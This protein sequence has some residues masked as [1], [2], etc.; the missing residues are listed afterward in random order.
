MVPG[1]RKTSS[2]SDVE[3]DEVIDDARTH[4]M[5]PL[6][7]IILDGADGG[8]AGARALRRRGVPVTMISKGWVTRARGIDGRR[9]TKRDEWLAELNDVASLGPGVLIP[10]SDPAVEFVARDR[11]LIPATLRSFEGPDSAHIKLMDKASLYSIAA[12]AGVRTPVVK[13]L[14]SR[15]ELEAVA[16]SAAYPSLLKPVLSHKYRELFGHHRNILVHDPDELKTA[17][18][19]ALDAGLDW[20]VTEVIPG[21]ETSLFGAVTIRLVD[22]SLALAYTRRKLRQHPPYFGAG[23]VLETV[24]APGAME[25]AERLLGAAGFV[26]FSSLEAKQHAVT[27]EHVLMEVNVRIPQNLGLGEAAGVDPTWRLYATLADIP[28]TPQRPQRNNVKV[29]VP[30]LELMAA[31]AYVRQGDMTVGDVLR[32]Y[33]GVRSISGLSM[34]DPVPLAAFVGGRVYNGVK[35]RAA[36]RREAKEEGADATPFRPGT[37]LKRMLPASARPMAKRAYYR[38]VGPGRRRTMLAEE[39]RHEAV[40]SRRLGSPLYGSLLERV[41]DDVEA[42]GPSW[43]LLDEKWPACRPVSVRLMGGV[44]R[45]VLEGAAPELARFY[46]SAGGTDSGDSWPAFRETLASQR[47]RLLGLLEHPVQTNEISRCS[48]LLSAFLTVSRETGLPL[49]LLE[50]GSSAGLLLRC[51]EYHYVERDLTWGDPESPARLEGAFADGSPPFD[52]SATVVERRGCDAAPLDPTSAEDRLTLMSYVWADE[53]WRFDLLRSALEVAQDVPVAGRGRRRMRLDR[54][55]A[56]GAGAGRRDGGVPLALHSLPRREAAGTLRGGPEGRRPARDAART[57]RAGE[58]R[59][60]QGRRPGGAAPHHLAW[61]DTPACDHRRPRPRDP[62]GRAVQRRGRAVGR[63][64]RLEAAARPSAGLPPALLAAAEVV[65]HEPPGDAGGVG[66]LLDRDL[67]VA[68]LG[69]QRVGGV[70]DLLAPLA[71]VEPAVARGRAHKPILNII[72]DT[73][74]TLLASRQH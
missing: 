48:A 69:E 60:A 7:A 4:M 45:L 55:S 29:I 35:A 2:A 72:D 17:A 43:Q 68:A 46:P 13:H 34:A 63:P 5:Q 27:G 9:A 41:A 1:R 24:P 33:R 21:A 15:D 62:L 74:R 37:A 19:P 12:E 65:V 8:Y 58:P 31:P 40:G 20:L 11:D 32:S 73:S 30:S 66:D 44:H 28:L 26:G 42:K 64:R 39:L 50:V 18:T 52:L 70:E 53:K 36:S 67:V 23:S 25:M 54:G 10:A 57:A 3:L 6:R 59:V 56:R 14:S 71:R 61:L 16:E 49:R 22:G 38:A 51:P 47:E